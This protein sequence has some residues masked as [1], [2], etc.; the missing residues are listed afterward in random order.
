MQSGIEKEQKE[1]FKQ[2]DVRLQALSIL[3]NNVQNAISYQ[4]Q[5]DRAKTL[6]LKPELLP[7]HG[8]GSTWDRNFMLE[9]ARQEIDNSALLISLLESSNGTILD[10]APVKEQED[11][12]RFGPDIIEQLKLKLKIMNAHWLDYNR[13]FTT[14]NL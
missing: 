9:T 13:I 5:L 8:A 2:L 1:Y 3:S 6:M 10:L 12:R 4:A 7:E 14:P 11:I